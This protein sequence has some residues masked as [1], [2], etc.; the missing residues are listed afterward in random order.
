MIKTRLAAVAAFAVAAL[1]GATSAQNVIQAGVSGVVQDGKVAV[2]NTSVFAEKIGELRQKYELVNNQ[3]KD[4]YQ[5]LQNLDT[6]VKQCEQDLKTKAPQMT[7]DKAAELQS[8]CEAIK[9]Q[10]QRKLEDFQSDYN[11]ALDAA[12]RPVRDKLQQFIQNYS[13]Q[14][15]IIL[16]MDLPVAVQSGTIAY[17]SPTSDI[18][19]DFIAEYNKANPVP[20]G[21]PAAQPAAAPPKPA[22]AKPPTGKP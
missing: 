21:A 5:D 11:K 7:A 2:V 18:T 22:P 12:T 15:S 4:R 13:V 8:Q 9:R 14:R 3:F 17:W 1:V 19:D 10:A 6:Q 16:I 20:A